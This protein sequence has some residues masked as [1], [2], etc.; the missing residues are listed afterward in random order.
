[1]KQKKI[2]KDLEKENLRLQIII[3]KQKAQIVSLRNYKKAS[4][5][6]RATDAAKR[7]ERVN[8]DG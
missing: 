8:Y 4:M 7:W 3:E 5:S 1:L 6:K 2:D